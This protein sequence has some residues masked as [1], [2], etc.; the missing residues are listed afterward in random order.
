[1]AYN[2]QYNTNRISDPTVKDIFTGAKAKYAS[3]IGIELTDPTDSYWTLP[4]TEL[5]RPSVAQI[6]DGGSPKFTDFRNRQ[7]LQYRRFDGANAAVNGT[8]AAFQYANGWDTVKQTFISAKYAAASVSKLG[9]YTVFNLSAPGVLGYGWGD[10]G[11]PRLVKDFT[12]QTNVVTRWQKSVDGGTWKPKIETA[13]IPFRGDK[14]NVIDY[15]QRDLD[16]V[17]L[18][19]PRLFNPKNKNLQKLQKFVGSATNLTR[20][21][22]KFYFTGPSLHNGSNEID[23]IMVFRAAITSLED[24][25]SPNWEDVQMIGRADPNYH[26]NGFNRSMQ[27]SFDIYATSRDE[28]KPIWRKLNAL[29]SYTTPTYD[30]KTIGLVAPWMR[31]TIGDLL[32]QQPVLIDSL[33]YTLADTDT[34]WETNIEDDP[35]MKQVPRK[36]SVSLGLKVITE[37]LPQKNGQ[38]YTLA[39][40]NDKF[41][42]LTGTDNWMS[43]A[44]PVTTQPAEFRRQATNA[45]K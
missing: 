41:G 20:D 36:I 18:W 38:F 22:I 8:I 3:S 21:F 32:V 28:L 27:M 26:Y 11:T 39:S 19:K 17:Y 44:T 30:T 12:L 24:T 6:Q 23:D 14:V 2:W 35:E 15:G 16:S 42:S 9:A 43:D 13:A 7:D 33:S 10:H 1:M 4:L 37:Y 5:Y 25:F 31:I 40:R 45:P 29:A 34:T